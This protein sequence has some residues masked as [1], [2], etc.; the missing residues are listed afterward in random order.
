MSMLFY[1]NDPWPLHDF[2][3]FECFFP[4][5]YLPYGRMLDHPPFL[6]SNTQLYTLET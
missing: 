2:S 4:L 1:K 5:A 6:S 3:L